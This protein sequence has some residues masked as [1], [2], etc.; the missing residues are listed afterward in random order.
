MS[1]NPEIDPDASWNAEVDPSDPAIAWN[2]GTRE[3]TDDEYARF[4]AANSREMDRV[5]AA[6]G[7]RTRHTQHGRRRTHRRQPRRKLKPRP[8]PGPGSRC[9]GAR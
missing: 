4:A 6:V 5:L 2:F 8:T 9:C 1:Q 7:K 3:L